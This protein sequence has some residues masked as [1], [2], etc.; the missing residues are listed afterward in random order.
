[1]KDKIEYAEYVGEI[2]E[3]PDYD[4]AL[5]AARKASGS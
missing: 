2:A 1:M 4:A 5:E 3:H